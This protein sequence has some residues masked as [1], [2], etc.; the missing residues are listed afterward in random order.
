MA[1]GKAALNV[2][3]VIERGFFKNAPPT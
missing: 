1:I 3:R 2:F